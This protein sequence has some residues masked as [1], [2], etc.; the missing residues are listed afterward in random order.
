MRLNSIKNFLGIIK[1]IMKSLKANYIKRFL[2]PGNYYKDPKLDVYYKIEFIKGKG[3]Y[4]INVEPEEL[5]NQKVIDLG[6]ED[7]DKKY[8]KREKDKNR[9]HLLW[10]AQKDCLERYVEAHGNH[11]LT[12]VEEEYDL[13]IFKR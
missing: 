8:F 2:E 7:I 12:Q 3:N 10:R 4:A 5:K 9:L 11:I 1:N 6:A 13:K